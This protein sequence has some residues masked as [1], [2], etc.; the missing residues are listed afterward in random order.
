DRLAA[1]RRPAAHILPPFAR[2]LDEVGEQDQERHSDHQKDDHEIEFAHAPRRCISR[3]GASPSLAAA[4][5]APAGGGADGGAEAAPDGERGGAD[6]AVAVQVLLLAEGGGEDEEAEDARGRAEEGRGED[7]LARGGAGGQPGE[8]AAARDA[9]EDGDLRRAVALEHGADGGGLEP[10]H[11]DG[12]GDEE[13]EEAG[14]GDRERD[15]E[16]PGD[17][18]PRRG[19]EELLGDRG[20]GE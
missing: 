17:R 4:D 8:Q 18:G 15:V 2:A 14:A 16:D 1:A 6:E 7:A 5:G 13:R 19:A 9:G 12:P 20:T 10:G 11:A 3:A